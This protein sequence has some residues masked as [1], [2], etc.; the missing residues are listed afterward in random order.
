MSNRPFLAEAFFQANPL[1]GFG[2]LDTRGALVRKFHAE[3]EQLRELREANDSPSLH[4]LQPT[5][6]DQP[7]P[8]MKIGMRSIW[9]HF[10][11]GTEQS[12][13]RHEA[14]R[15]IESACAIMGATR[16]ARQGLRLQYLFGTRDEQQAA[17]DLRRIGLGNADAW[18]RLG[19]LATMRLDLGIVGDTLKVN[20]SMM[21][22]RVLQTSV[23]RAAPSE[24]MTIPAVDEPSV[25]LMLDVDIY[26][27]RPS[28][29]RDPNPFLR[30]ALHHMAEEIMPLFIGLLERQ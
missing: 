12:T 1:D 10:R 5:D 20:V 28:E 4:F 22:V 7:V 13:M 3:F 27:D 19:T 26:D 9:V 29:S 2:F 16:F 14:N 18:G 24:M 6:S 11:S 23:V 21:P 30:R 25:G 15:I 8:E 17:A